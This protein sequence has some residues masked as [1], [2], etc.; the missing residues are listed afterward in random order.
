[1]ADQFNL[2]RHSTTENRK[3]GAYI[4]TERLKIY[5]PVFSSYT[6]VG[7]TQT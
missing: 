4:Y 2:Q 3:I 5:L 1:M 6:H 7:M